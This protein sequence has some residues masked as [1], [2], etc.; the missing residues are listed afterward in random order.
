MTVKGFLSFCWFMMMDKRSV[1]RALHNK[2]I[3]LV[4]QRVFLLIF[5][6][7]SSHDL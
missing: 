6:T 7:V 2:A 3:R 4:L 5:C 1:A